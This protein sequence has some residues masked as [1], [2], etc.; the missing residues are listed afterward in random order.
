[1]ITI[2]ALNGSI[3]SNVLLPL[4]QGAQLVL[5]QFNPCDSNIY[6]ILNNYP[7]GISLVRYN[8]SANTINTTAALNPGNFICTDCGSVLDPVNHFYIY[9]DIFNLNGIDV[10]N[11][12]VVYNTPVNDLP[13]ESF[14][15]LTIKCST[16]EIFGTSTNFNSGIKYLAILNPGSGSVAHVS[17]TGWSMGL[18]T[19]AGSGA[20]INQQSGEFFYVS[21]DTLIGINT[22]TGNLSYNQTIN[23][24]DLYFIQHFSQCSCFPN[25]INYL[26]GYKNSI[27]YPNPCIGKFKIN[28]QNN[29]SEK[30]I[31]IYNITGNLI[32][33]KE[34]IKNTE[35]KI[36][37]S[38]QPKGIYFL[39]VFDEDK[40][41]VNKMVLQ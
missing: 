23:S 27:L 31:C 35:E 12:Q 15:S 26:N 16:H 39:K 13:N 28:F 33:Q 8:I 14:Q 20:F 19:N 9:R 10:L 6:G 34:K 30:T 36:N 24:G 1:L 11:G 40:I 29:L 38:N 7:S 17:N 32:Y 5:I 37:L 18:F 3:L 22:S 41:S 4:P 21:G 25:E 2:D